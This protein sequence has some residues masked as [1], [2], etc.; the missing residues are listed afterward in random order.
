MIREKSIWWL[1]LDGDAAFARGP[2]AGA[3]DG[4]G[5]ESGFDELRG[6]R[7]LSGEKELRNEIDLYSRDFSVSRYDKST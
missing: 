4:N 6:K 1:I 7:G 3:F 2:E 5:L